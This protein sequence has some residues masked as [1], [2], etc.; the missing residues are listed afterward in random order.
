[1]ALEFSKYTKILFLLPTFV[2]ANKK[3][4]RRMQDKS[5]SYSHSGGNSLVEIHAFENRPC[6]L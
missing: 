5:I 4:F 2:Y 1:M 3:Y 6:Y